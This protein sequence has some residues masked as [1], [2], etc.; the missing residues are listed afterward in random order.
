MNITISRNGVTAV[1]QSYG[2]E[3]KSC[4]NGL[5]WHGDPE[6]W[7][8]HT[9]VLFPIV[10]G[11]KDGR[12]TFGSETLEIRKHGFAR[13]SEFE[14]E[15][16]DGESVTWLLRPNDEIR[17]MYPFDF[18]FRVRHTLVSCGFETAYTVTNTGDVTMPFCIG[19]H[20][21]FNVPNHKRWSLEFSLDENCDY[22]NVNGE[23]ML[24]FGRKAGHF[25]GRELP[26]YTDGKDIF[27]GGA[28]IMPEIKSREV[29]LKND[30]D[31]VRIRFGFSDFDMLAF[32]TPAGKNAPFVCLE[33]WCG[34]PACVGESGRFEDKPHAMLLGKGETK[35]FK[36]EV[37]VMYSR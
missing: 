9:P 21:A 32:W 5:I 8:N 20:P 4:G 19:G 17:R 30:S 18:E 1:S 28:V 16:T 22:Y 12:V 3:L 27:D 2:A 7:A 25:K 36:F 26:F 35:E 24:D 37:S 11:L 14:L 31:T 13:Y 6:I 23:G 15:E 29:V 10:G 34:M 33:P